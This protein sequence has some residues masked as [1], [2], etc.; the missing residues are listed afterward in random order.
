MPFFSK[1]NKIALYSLFKY[2]VSDNQ[3]TIWFCDNTE[4]IRKG[5]LK[6]GFWLTA[7]SLTDS[8]ENIVR[9][10]E[11][12]GDKTLFPDT[13]KIVFKRVKPTDRRE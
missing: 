8:T 12:G 10:L 1:D 6:G 7:D 3:L 11:Q 5:E 2:K 13:L 4:V 9:Y